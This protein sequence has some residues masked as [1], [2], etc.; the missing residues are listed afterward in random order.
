MI[1][2]IRASTL[3]GLR[4]EADASWHQASRSRHEAAIGRQQAAVADARAAR[5][6]ARYAA[7]E[8]DTMACLVRLNGA[9]VQPEIRHSVRADLA[10]T[11]LRNQIDRIRAEGTPEEIKSIEVLDVLTGPEFDLPVPAVP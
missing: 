5:A 1:R 8:A 3:A 6:E 11:Y 4:A 9:A 7:L 2:I 10:L